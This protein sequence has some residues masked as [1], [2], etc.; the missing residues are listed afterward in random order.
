VAGDG[1]DAREYWERRLRDQFSLSGVGA[2]GLSAR[3]LRWMYR[4]RR[5]VFE[6]T[7]RPLVRPGMRVLDVGSGTGFYI[8]CWRRV[9]AARLYGSD[10]TSEA[11][12]RLAMRFPNVRFA[13]FEAGADGDPFGERFDVISA[14]D[15]LFHIVD[16]ER[17]R[18]AVRDLARLLA[19]GGALVM[20]ENFLHAGELRGDHHV[21]RDVDAITGAIVAGGLMIAERRPMFMLMSEPVDATGAARRGWWSLVRWVGSTGWPSEVLGAGLYPVERLLIHLAREAP[22]TEIAVCRAAPTD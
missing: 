6:R 12:R 4:V 14:M 15:V 8:E 16:D 7:V 1:F 9:G 18:R 17:Y 10:L 13:R 21:S 2:I 11:V 3:Y 19:P 5:A 20:S 22:S